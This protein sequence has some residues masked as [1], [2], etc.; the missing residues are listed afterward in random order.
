[1]HRYNYYEKRKKILNVFFLC[2]IINK[3]IMGISIFLYFCF[4][5]LNLFE[6]ILI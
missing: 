6:E 2:D 4:L 5:N 3:I 1:M